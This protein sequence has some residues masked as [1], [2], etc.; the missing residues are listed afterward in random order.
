M[1]PRFVVTGGPGGGKTTALTALEA[2]GYTVVSEGAR[3]IIK[4]RLAIG[5]PPRPDPVS[6]AQAILKSDVEKHRNAASCEHAVFFDRGVLDALYM[7]NVAGALTREEIAQYVRQFPYNRLVFLFPPWEEI[8]ATDLER[9]QSFAESVEVFNGMRRWYSQW[10]Y[11][12]V[13]V[14]RGSVNERVSFMLRCIETL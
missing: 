7:L 10:G 9:D 1:N 5:L 12:T 11:K 2:Q 14:P 4:E 3:R 8:Y 6:F 13:D